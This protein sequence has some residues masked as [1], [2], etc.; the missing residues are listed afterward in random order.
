MINVKI[1]NKTSKEKK[2]VII[3][4]FIGITY[5]DIQGEIV[6]WDLIPEDDKSN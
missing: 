1:K 4:C 3:D 5:F 2:K 6:G